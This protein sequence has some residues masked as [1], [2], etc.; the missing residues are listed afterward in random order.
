MM[1]LEISDSC[2]NIQSQKRLRMQHKTML[3]R[4]IM[5]KSILRMFFFLFALFFS[6]SCKKLQMQF[7]LRKYKI[8]SETI[9]L[10]FPSYLHIRTE[11]LIYKTWWTRI[12]LRFKKIIYKKISFSGTIFYSGK[13]TP[14]FLLYS[15]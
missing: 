2:Y 6:L 12:F 14:N 1:Y 5:Q 15:F 3:V 4:F 8:T 10:H 13:K 7:N 9:Q 11:F